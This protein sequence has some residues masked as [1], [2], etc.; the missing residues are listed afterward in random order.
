VCFGAAFFPHPRA[1]GA[2]ISF[3]AI[4]PTDASRYHVD[5]ARHYYASPDAERAARVHTRPHSKSLKAIARVAGSAA[6]LA[7]LQ[8]RDRAEVEFMRHYTYLY[9]RYA[10]DTTDSASNAQAAD[11][12]AQF[13][14]RSEFLVRELADIDAATL[15]RY[16]A[17]ESRLGA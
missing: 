12:D 1:A 15:A 11:L 6:S 2:D 5:L 14:A 7:A 9:L 16:V 17:E 10:V 4:S 13:T 3:V 8:A